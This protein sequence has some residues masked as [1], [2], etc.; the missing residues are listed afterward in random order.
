M[1]FASIVLTQNTEHLIEKQRWQACRAVARDY[2]SLG[3]FH[4]H[5]TAAR[6]AKLAPHIHLFLMLPDDRVSLWKAG[7]K[8]D[9]ARRFDPALF[10]LSSPKGWIIDPDSPAGLL[11]YAIGQDRSHTPVPAYWASGKRYPDEQRALDALLNQALFRPG[12]A[13]GSFF[14]TPKGKQHYV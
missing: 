2:P 1:K 4:S 14:V 13:R 10:E 8:A 9:L 11:R 7:A 12:T 3:Y 5:Q 6:G